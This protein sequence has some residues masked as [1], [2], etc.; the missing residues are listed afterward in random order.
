MNEITEYQIVLGGMTVLAEKVNEL[1]NLGWQPYGN[2]YAM[3]LRLRSA[4]YGGLTDEL[5]HFQPMVK[6]KRIDI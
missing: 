5:H 3:I 1:I 4:S 6:T 2:A